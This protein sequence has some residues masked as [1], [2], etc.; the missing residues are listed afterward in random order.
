MDTVPDQE[1]LVALV[2]DLEQVLARARAAIGREAPA[3]PSATFGIAAALKFSKRDR[4]TLLR[5]AEKCPGLAWKDA[6][7]RWQ[8][9]KR[10]LA[11]LAT[12]K[13]KMGGFG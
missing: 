7:G 11:D 8:F 10:K 9:D 6:G 13:P 4:K 12:G 5:W 3:T 1:A 2:A